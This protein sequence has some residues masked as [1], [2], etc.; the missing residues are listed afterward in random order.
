MATELTSPAAQGAHFGRYIEDMRALWDRDP[1]G[2]AAASPEFVE[3]ARAL[4]IRL[5]DDAPDTEPWIAGLIADQVSARELYRDPKHGFIQMGHYHPPAELG[6]T[7]GGVPHDHGPCWVLY[8]VYRGGIEITRFGRTDDGRDPERATLEQR[9]VVDIVPGTVQPYFPTD[10]H[11]TRQ[12]SPTGSIVMRFL[13]GDLET[14]E[15]WRYD[16]T[17]GRRKRV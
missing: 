12:L 11:R 17:T 10:Q 9:E 4:L 2:A 3:E 15:R 1:A 8:G 14:V 13:S 6:A 16:L 7:G 5:L